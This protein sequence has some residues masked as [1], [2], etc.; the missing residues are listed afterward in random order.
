MSGTLVGRD[1]TGQILAW[2][3]INFDGRYRPRDEGSRTVST[4]PVE[5]LAEVSV[6]EAPVAVQA[7]QWFSQAA[8]QLQDAAGWHDTVQR[9]VELAAAL[10]EA[11]LAV[12]IASS[13]ADDRPRVLA[14]TDFARA[15]AMLAGQNT[16][17]VVPAR[18]AM[19]DRAVIHVPDLTVQG[20]WSNRQ[21]GTLSV[22]LRCVLAFPLLI[23]DQPLAS[24]GLYAQQPGAFS[25]EVVE[26]AA[27]F[28][29]HAAIAFNAA[30]L[31]EKITNL[32]VALEHARDIG[33]AVGIIMGLL[34]ITQ[35]EAFDRL[36]VASQ[37]RNV[38]LYEVALVTVHTG[39][40]PG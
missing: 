29:E 21:A 22:P 7:V 33:A 10:V 31:A 5:D 20:S 8:R 40:V 35:S 16:A 17:G 14:A 3:N 30:A 24:L 18:Q 1:T 28:A 27:S 23:D 38:K 11:D 13:P 15:D 9:I 26:L 19:A 12:I 6:S 32:T 25:D 2:P 36:R 4:E 34:H 37:H 39:E